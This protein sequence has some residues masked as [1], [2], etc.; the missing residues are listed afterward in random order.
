MDNEKR[1]AFKSMT[2]IM[3]KKFIAASFVAAALMLSGCADKNAEPVAYNNGGDYDPLEPLNRCIYRFNYVVDGVL[4]KPLAQLYKAVTPKPVQEG[5]S[6]F[7]SNLGSP[8]SFANSAVQGNDQ[9]A[10]TIMWRFILNTTLGVGGVFD[11]AG[12]YG[13]QARSEDFGQT[14]GRYGVGAGPYIVL[15][16]LGPSSARDTVGRVADWFTDPFN[17]YTTGYWQAGRSA[18]QGLVKRADVLELTDE[19]YRTSLDPYATFRSGYLQ[20]R[21]NEV[22]LRK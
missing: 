21:A 3:P 20:Y 14:M 18:S 1:F 10:F 19:V 22:K 11:F 16:I 12:Q 15:P 2:E 17:Y 5:V 6:N 4:I 9:Q 7:F 8:V 13:L